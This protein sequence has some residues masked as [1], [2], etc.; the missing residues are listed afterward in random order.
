M[1]DCCV[2]PPA[3]EQH[4]FLVEWHLPTFTR[5]FYFGSCVKKGSLKDRSVL[6][7]LGNANLVT[8]IWT[9]ALPRAL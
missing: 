9:D 3:A 2:E 8:T 5:G 6:I 7:A 4:V 1:V